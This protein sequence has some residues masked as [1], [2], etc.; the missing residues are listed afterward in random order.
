VIGGKYADIRAG[1][2]KDKEDPIL[3]SVMNSKV[4][5]SEN[6]PGAIQT[7]AVPKLRLVVQEVRSE[8]VQQNQ[9]IDF[10]F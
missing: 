6:M 3:S 1:R 5:R 2:R 9:I 7:T 10:P 4:S 8:R